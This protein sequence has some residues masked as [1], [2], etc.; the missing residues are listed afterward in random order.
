MRRKIIQ[1]V[2]LAY[3]VLILCGFCRILVG[4]V[5]VDLA[6]FGNVHGAQGEVCK[7]AQS[8]LPTGPDQSGN[9]LRKSNG[10]SES[11]KDEV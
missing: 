2:G 9:W 6:R 3:V 10:E 11:A 7:I 5:P 4:L 8:M 1:Q